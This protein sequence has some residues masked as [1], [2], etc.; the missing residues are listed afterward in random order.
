VND[1]VAG[2]KDADG[3]RGRSVLVT[4][5]GCGLGADLARAAARAGARVALN[6]R[7]NLTP[8]EALASEL[9]REGA[10]VSVCAADVTDAAQAERLAAETARA[11]GG[12]DV[13]VNTVG[14]FGWHPVIETDPA[15]WRRMLG[16]NLDSVFNTCRAVLPYMRQKHCGRIV[17]I[18]AVGAERAAGEPKIAAYCAAKAGVVAFS[19]ALALEEARHGITVNVVSPGVLPSD[20][21]PEPAPTRGSATW[22]DRVPVG[23]SGAPEDVVRAVL[24]FATPA[25]GFVTG[26]VLAVAGGWHL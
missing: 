14:S 3:L 4:G 13:L 21:A 12:I 18:G 24:F 1:P 26:Q 25:A 9:R 19:K 23:R 5:S 16:S 7:S 11:F 2:G 6:C 20:G 10:Q 8:V 17:N 15:E 22:A